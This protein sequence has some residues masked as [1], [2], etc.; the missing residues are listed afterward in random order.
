[1]MEQNTPPIGRGSDE[2]PR[3]CRSRPLSV[4][5]DPTGR[6]AAGASPGHRPLHERHDPLQQ[7]APRGP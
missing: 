5:H 6:P 1:M 2:Q 4:L 3:S 7:R